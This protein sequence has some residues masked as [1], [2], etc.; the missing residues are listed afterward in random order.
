MY[1]LKLLMKNIKII[2]ITIQYTNTYMPE[3]QLTII[4]IELDI[5]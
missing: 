1:S 3:V 4:N 2:I 5:R